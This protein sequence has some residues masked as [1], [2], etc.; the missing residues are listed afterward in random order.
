MRVA[1]IGAGAAGLSIINN[2]PVE[3]KCTY[4]IFSDHT[5]DR[6]PLL[7]RIPLLGGLLFGDTN[8]VARTEIVSG[9]RRLP[10]YISKV[11]GG[12]TAINGCVAT[13]GSEIQWREMYADRFD[14]DPPIFKVPAGY[15]VKPF[16]YCKLDQILHDELNKYG[17]TSCN[18]L[19]HNRVGH[20]PVQIS[21][22]RFFRSTL[23]NRLQKTKIINESVNGLEDTECSVKVTTN[24][25]SYDYDRVIICAGVLGT[26]KLLSN[27]SSLYNGDNYIKDH[28]NFRIKVKLKRDAPFESLNCVER[29]FLK[30]TE[31]FANYVLFDKGL[32]QGPGA[33]YVIYQDFDGDG[34]VDTKI[35]LLNFTE[36]GRLNAQRNKYQFDNFPGIS[37][38]ITLINQGSAGVYNTIDDNITFNYFGSQIEKTLIQKAVGYV[39]ELIKDTELAKHVDCIIDEDMFCQD[40]YLQNV[41]S[42]YHFISGH[43]KFNGWNL[44][45]DLSLCG[46][47]KIYV[48]DASSFDRFVASNTALPVALMAE[49]WIKTRNNKFFNC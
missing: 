40:Y 30:K 36:G 28:P 13:L 43:E 22:N 20:G 12:A 37:F 11:L 42:G 3:K 7:N 14:T 19:F 41:Y 48:V 8:Y 47:Q 17:L 10:F 25:A 45:S 21:R 39:I 26:L 1:I 24:R 35:Q 4:T 32:M 38:A 18:T 49:H 15:N 27:F 6:L 44:N 23:S 5:N 16:V 29:N 2:F 31:L 34:V 9:I 46:S 33:S